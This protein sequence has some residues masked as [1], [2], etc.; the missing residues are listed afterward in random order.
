M[1]PFVFVNYDRTPLKT[2]IVNTGLSVK[3]TMELDDTKLEPQVSGGGLPSIYRFA[4]FHMHWG[5]DDSQGSEHT[6]SK[7]KFPMELHL[8]HYNAHYGT[9]LGSAIANGQ[10]KGATDTLAVLGIMFQLDQK[11]NKNLDPMLTQDVKAGL[12]EERRKTNTKLF[13]LDTLLPEDTSRFYRYNGSLTTP[14]CNEIVVWTVFKDPIKISHAQLEAFRALAKTSPQ[15]ENNYR[16]P[17]PLYG[18]AVLDVNTEY[19][20]AGAESH[21]KATL[22]FFSLFIVFLVSRFG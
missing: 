21:N 1:D 19:G 12:V 14:G 5:V 18:R 20:Y 22:T 3:M 17:Q 9:D 15:I 6:I 2:F 10:K 11:P 16:P 4:Q 13:E 8:V 7:T